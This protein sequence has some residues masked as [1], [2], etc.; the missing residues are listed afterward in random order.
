VLRPTRFFALSVASIL[1]STGIVQ[2][3]PL[4]FAFNET[5]SDSITQVSSDFPAAP[6]RS[7]DQQRSYQ[8]WKKNFD[9]LPPEQQAKMKAKMADRRKN[10]EMM[11]EQ[12][13]KL[14]PEQQAE[15]KAKIA[16]WQKERESKRDEIRTMTPEARRAYLQARR[17][18]HQEFLQKYGLK[19]MD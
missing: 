17:A 11:R 7:P 5:P 1:L 10:R 3:K 16:A 8:S 12:I 13:A 15:V 19:P 18:E 14:P 2:A 4:I 9:T 6:E